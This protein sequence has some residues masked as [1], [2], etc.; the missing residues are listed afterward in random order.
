M[1]ANYV[2]IASKRDSMGKEQ[3]VV[4][5]PSATSNQISNSIV[6]ALWCFI[7]AKDTKRTINT[8]HIVEEGEKQEA[9]YFYH[10]DEDTISLGFPPPLMYTTLLPHSTLFFFSHL[11]S[12]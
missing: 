11:E 4:L 10:L 1:S 7:W 12:L 5:C 8:T 3:K 6:V 2:F 9:P